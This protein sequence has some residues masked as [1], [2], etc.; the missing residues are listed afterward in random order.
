MVGVVRVEAA[1]DGES[2]DAQRVAPRSD[3]DRFE[4]PLFDRRAYERVDLCDD[5]GREGLFEPPF[6]AASSEAAS[7]ASISVSAHRSQA[8]Q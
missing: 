4:V 1:G 3:F 5:L 2:C 8:S 7:G 6:F